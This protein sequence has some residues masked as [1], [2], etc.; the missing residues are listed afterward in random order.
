MFYPIPFG[1][2]KE[3]VGSVG[4]LLGKQGRIPPPKAPTPAL[5][6]PRS[7][8]R[9]CCSSSRI[10]QLRPAQ[11]SIFIRPPQARSRLIFV[12]NRERRVIASYVTQDGRPPRADLSQA[13]RASGRGPP[14]LIIPSPNHSLKLKTSRHAA[15]VK[16]HRSQHPT[17]SRSDGTGP[18]ICFL[19]MTCAFRR[20]VPLKRQ[21]REAL[22]YAMI[23]HGKRCGCHW[24]LMLM[25]HCRET[26]PS[27]THRWPGVADGF[28]LCLWRTSCLGH[29]SLICI[30]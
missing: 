3:W 25:M 8:L 26:A 29:G 30:K 13:W 15:F 19:V 23:D 22:C 9:N 4:R 10:F 1:C 7:K 11:L 17:L 21:D 18:L 5:L 24:A 6:N 12:D 16:Q 14:E 27:F 20:L 28:L 2:L